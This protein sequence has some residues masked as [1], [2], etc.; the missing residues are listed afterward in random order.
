MGVNDQATSPLLG[1]NK[2]KRF[3]SLN[4][5]PRSCN[6]ILFAILFILACAG[7]VAISA[8]AFKRGDPQ[9]LIPTGTPEWI[10]KYEKNSTNVVQAWFQDAVAQAK[11]DSDIL[12]GSVALALVL[13]LV[14]IQLMKTFTKLFIY[15]SLFLGV[16]GVVAVGGY[17][18][19]M[20][21]KQNNE[22]I[23]VIG[24]VL[25]GIAGF[26]LLAVIFLRKKI[27]ITC[28]MFTETCRGVQHNFSLF[29]IS[30]LV[31]SVFLGFAAYW[32]ASF[33]YLYSI[34]GESINPD[35]TTPPTFDERIRNL[36]FFL[37]F[38][39]FW[40][41]AFLSAVFQHVVAGAIA[42]W[43]FSRDVTGP[44]PTGIPALTSLF[45]AV[46][47]SFG[48]LAFGSLLIAVVEFLNF[49]LQH[50]KRTN[51]KNK[52]VVYVASC[53][54]CVLGCIESIVR[55]VNKFAYIY[56]AMHGHS[57]CTAARECFDLISRNFFTTVIMDVISGF[58][59]FMGKILF[60]AISVLLTIG[61]IDNL[62]RNL[63]IVTVTLTGV[64][65]FVVLH[66]ISH[67][68]GAGIN[69]VFVCYLE[70]LENSKDGNLYI[71]P[72]VHRMLQEKVDENRAKATQV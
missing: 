52:L 56:V 72:D 19:S 38:V 42:T 22:G 55:Y 66:I 68:V 60:T 47:T 36:M 67:V 46:T 27:A 16:A 29:P 21:Y 2:Q 37:V 63:S 50:A 10:N 39:F 3:Q 33:I 26:L 51:S 54:Q 43:Y 8:V 45:R 59:L 23:Q 62:G 6:D 58:V 34:P 14:W 9:L 1:S 20:G 35:S 5:A 32:V 70:D 11:V 41:A 61:I 57:F 13:G 18:L 48:S 71:S 69:A 65:S 24:Y 7:M 44:R 40:V 64:I 25:F 49:I 15:L 31:I 28:A 30:F 17:F 12:V 4:D 53:L